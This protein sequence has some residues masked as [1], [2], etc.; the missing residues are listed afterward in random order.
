MNRSIERILTTHAGSLPRGPKLAA[1][2]IDEEQG[3]A[4]DRQ[5]MRDEMERRV[6]HVFLKLEECGIDV[7]NDGEQPR[8]GFQTYIAQRM[9][10]F[11]G[12]SQRI[13]PQDFTAWPEHAARMLQ[14]MGEGA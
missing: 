5:A 6:A 13:P 12:E 10:G 3:K 7:P 14:A 11:G 9:T 4:G 2:L 1:M 8:V